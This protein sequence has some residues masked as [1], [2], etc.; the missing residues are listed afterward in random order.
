MA[1][2]TSQLWTSR[3][4][5]QCVTK[6]DRFYCKQESIF[7]THYSDLS[8]CFHVSFVPGGNVNAVLFRTFPKVALHLWHR[9][10]R[11]APDFMVYLPIYI[12][13]AWR[14]PNTDKK[15]FTFSEAS[16]KKDFNHILLHWRN[17]ENGRAYKRE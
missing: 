1:G 6:A 4:K 16:Q 10:H 7:H 12:N 8:L 3:G 2:F 17:R 15:E 14:E 9:P 5:H 11:I 13:K